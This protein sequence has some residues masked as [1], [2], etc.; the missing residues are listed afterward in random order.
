MNDKNAN[1]LR[2]L[3]ADII[4]GCTVAK[5]RGEKILVKHFTSIDHG[6]ID[7]DYDRYYEE[8]RKKGLL[9]SEEKL[10]S[11]IEYGLWSKDDENWIAQQKF[12][13]SNLILTKGKLPWQSEVDEMNKTIKEAEDALSIKDKERDEALGLVAE[14]YAN[15][16]LNESYIYHA[17]RAHSNV[18]NRLFE[19]TDFSEFSN[20]EMDELVILYNTSLAPFQSKNLKRIGLA[21]FFQSVYS[22]CEDNPYTFFGKPVC[23]LTFYQ[24][25]IFTYG[26]FFKFILSGEIKPEESIMDDPDKIIEWH[27]S[28]KNAQSMV[29]QV[30][31]DTNG[32]T[33][34]F[35][36]KKSDIEKA[37]GRVAP[38]LITK[39]M[40]EG[41][42]SLSM[43]EIMKHQGM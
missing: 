35:G 19:E 25:E 15:H 37:G 4:Q 36:T 32:S 3:Y 5:Y 38:S 29:G 34:V 13:I 7:S 17:F 26:R 24:S 22:I 39:A 11:I 6:D 18:E 21:S 42:K 31:D 2:K 40:K 10:E 41:K 33:M 43:D 16:K 9:N 28:S 30:D 14:K 1:F 20:Q 27:T 23:N 12:Y 8:A